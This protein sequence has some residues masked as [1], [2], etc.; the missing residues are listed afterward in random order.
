M[1]QMSR[2]GI[3]QS[4]AERAGL[5]ETIDASSIYPDL[6]RLPAIVF[7][8]VNPDGSPMMFDRGEFIRIRLLG[9]SE[10]KGFIKHKP[11]RYAQPSRSGV[12]AYFPPLVNWQQIAADPSYPL[13]ITEGEAKALVA[14][15]NGFP[16]IGLGGVS[17][18][19]VANTERLISDLK[20]I[21]WRRP[22]RFGLVFDSD[23]VTNRFVLLAETRLIRVLQSDYGAEGYIFRLPQDGDSKVGLDDFLNTRGKEAFQELIEKATKVEHLDAKIM[24]LNERYSLIDSQCAIWDSRNE[25]WVKKD[26]FLEGSDAACIVHEVLGAETRSPAASGQAAKPKV[27][28]VAKAWLRSPHATRYADMQYDPDQD[29]VFSDDRGRRI[30]NKWHPYDAE[31]GDPEPFLKLTEFLFGDLDIHDENGEPLREHPV[32]LLAW[33]AQ[34]PAE[35]PKQCIIL[36]S[37]EGSGKGLWSGLLADAFAPWSEPLRASDL[38]NNFQGWLQTTQLAVVNEAMP[39]D[40]QKGSEIFKSLI[41]DEDHRMNEKYQVARKVKN[42]S[43]FIVTA[44]LRAAAHTP[45]NDRRF[46]VVECP[47]KYRIS[48]DK[49]KIAEF[50]GPIHEW[51]KSGGGKIVMHYLL[52]YPLEGWEPGVSPPITPEKIIAQSEGMDALT[53]FAA[54]IAGA[55]NEH[56]LVQSL[57]TAEA[58]CTA[59]Q[60]DAHKGGACKAALSEYDRVPLKPFMTAEEI[61]RVMP[62]LVYTST[63]L[64]VPEHISAGQLSERLRNQGIKILRGTDPR[65]FMYQGRRQQ[66]LIMY[67]ADEFDGKRLTQSEFDRLLKSAPTFGDYKRHARSRAATE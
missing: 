65:G 66:F 26:Y 51:R 45:R 9:Q 36:T 12:R 18:W 52:N 15:L 24:Q 21:D 17:N 29:T 1:A 46:F 22:R 61:H 28:Q 13:L 53:S 43:L 38:H 44:N 2:W 11:Q 50:F 57:L 16:T 67:G 62:N 23:A 58:Y 49:R 31:P 37:D 4:D 54:Q 20:L 34:N 60:D 8:Y 32:R 35:K 48:K 30:L 41:G 63:G 56:P 27:I 5:S 6:P 47:S 42:Y 55:A 39:T 3:T 14:T 19:N 33:H 25:Q 10:V 40:L 59:M 64:R 7:P